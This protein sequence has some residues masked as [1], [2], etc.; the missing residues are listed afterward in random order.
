[1]CIEAGYNRYLQPRNYGRGEG[2]GILIHMDLP[3]PYISSFPFSYSDYLYFMFNFPFDILRIIVIYRSP[4][5]EYSIFFDKLSDCINDGLHS[6]S[7]KLIF[8]GDFNY[9]FDSICQPHS[10]FRQLTEYLGLHQHISCPTHK[11]GNI[12]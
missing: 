6:S 4:R 3:M 8:M 12:I 11:S 5:P 2:V 7:F 1:M 10:L 9:H